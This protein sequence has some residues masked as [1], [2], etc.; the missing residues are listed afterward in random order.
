MNAFLLRPVVILVGIVAIF[1]CAVADE[2]WQTVQLETQESDVSVG[3]PV[4]LH[5]PNA[6]NAQVDLGDL[7]KNPLT[8]TD[9]DKANRL[10]GS[11]SASEWLGPLAP[12]AISPF[13]GV[14]IL[15]GLAEFGGDWMPA[16]EFISNNAILKNPAV[17]WVFLALTILTSIP[18]FTKISKPAAQAV[19]QLEAYAGII[20]IVLL[21]V[22]MM[23][24]DESVAAEQPIIMQAGFLSVSADMLMCIAAVI[25]IVVINTV[26]FFFEV[27]V[28][29][30]PFP[31][32]DAM[33]EVANKSVCAALMAVYAWSPVVATILNLIILGVC[34]IAFRWV[35]RRTVYLRTML[36]DPV[37]VIAWPGYAVPKKKRLTVFAKNGIGPFAAKARLTIEPNETGW[38]LRAKNLVLPGATHQ[39]DRAEV[40][41]TMQ[42]GVLG[43]RINFADGED[44]LI[45]SRRYTGRLEELADLLEIKIVQAASSPDVV[46]HDL[47]GA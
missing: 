9:L 15:A 35:Y 19:D 30:M 11:V 8:P 28:W 47:Q 45:F 46:T 42:K 20:T 13:F 39:I 12:I 5:S 27:S 34:L 6:L 16:N 36:L 23:T 40:V 44:Q 14:T 33:L 37:L 32:V 17:F 2:Q 43:N 18:R 38:M 1:P 24:A 22:M 21:R 4:T 26:K 29:L 7:T 25:N 10:V 31:F 41:L 3:R